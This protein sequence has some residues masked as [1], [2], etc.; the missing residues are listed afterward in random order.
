LFAKLGRKRITIDAPSMI[1]VDAIIADSV[2]GEPDVGAIA[3]VD[4]AK[5]KLTILLW[6]YHDVAGGYEDRRTVRLTLVG[7]P[8]TAKRAGAVEY[9]IDETSGNA[10][11]AWLA[12]GSPQAPTARQIAKLHTASRMQT[13]ARDL[14]R[15][16]SGHTGL[17]VVLPRQSVKLIEVDLSRQP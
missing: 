3:S 4:D 13:V 6:N 7:L 10:Y 8:K 12:M 11:T 15:T 16:T 9:S 17:D 5:S 14:I 2:R 1:P